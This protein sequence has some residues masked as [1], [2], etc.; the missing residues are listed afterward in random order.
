MSLPQHQNKIIGPWKLERPSTLNLTVALHVCSQ[1]TKEAALS[2]ISL[3]QRQVIELS[4]QTQWSTAPVD[5]IT[6]HLTATAD[7]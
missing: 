4:K 2:Q 5:F 7:F 1:P 3:K 6:L